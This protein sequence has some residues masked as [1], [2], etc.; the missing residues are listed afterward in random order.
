MSRVEIR[1]MAAKAIAQGLVDVV[2]IC[3]CRRA[4]SADEWERLALVGPCDLDDK[5]LEIRH[6]ECGSC[7]SVIIGKIFT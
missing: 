4:Y 7:I 6:C 3:A 5:T 1:A 2:K